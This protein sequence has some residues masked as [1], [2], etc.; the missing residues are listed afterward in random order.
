MSTETYH[1]AFGT[2]RR[3][4]LVLGRILDMAAYCFKPDAP[5][6]PPRNLDLALGDGC[7]SELLQVLEDVQ[8]KILP[9]AIQV[10][11]PQAMAHM[12]P[13][14][15]TV[16]VVADLL[17]GLMN[18][19]AFIWEEAPVA[20]AL[21]AEV[22]RWLCDQLHLPG[23]STAYLTS[24]GTASNHLATLCAIERAGRE[25]A[26]TERYCIVASDQAHLSLEKAAFATGLGDH[27]V[28]R[29]PTDKRGR[30]L[31]GRFG[32]T[33]M[34]VRREGRRPI[35]FVCTA[36]TPSAGLIEPID[37]ILQTARAHSGWCHV[38]AAYGGM[39][40]MSRGSNESA[41]WADADSLSWD[42]HKCLYVTY[43]SGAF[44][45]RDTEALRCLDVHGDYALK[46]SASAD[47]GARHLDGSRRLEALKLWMTI[48]YFG[49]EGF[50]DMTER[51]RHA[52]WV[53]ARHVRSCS[54]FELL[55]EPDTNVVCFRY[56]GGGQ[57]ESA[58]DSVNEAVQHNLFR[59]GGP[60]VST[61][62]VGGRVWLRAVL[63]NP[64]VEECDIVTSL[65][66]IRRE[67]ERQAAGTDRRNAGGA[68][69]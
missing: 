1:D 32:E 2:P 66:S 20:S 51:T 10:R 41:R 18:Q 46:A 23:H 24:G 13:P 55:T 64:R 65:R 59:T 19:C 63:L 22:L 43:A 28:V 49:R 54:D 45:L 35:L 50:A 42:P 67:A 52:A 8:Q 16:A 44:F 36:G 33:A 17:I 30:L 58:S 38:D 3:A 61:T 48:K 34:R 5:F 6:A 21:E 12:V 68:S 47:P 9:H 37:E 39:L 40:C 56:V 25:A 14:P 15:A 29:V 57:A 26:R 7:G 27:S 4:A 69:R 11:H 53:F 62:R 31:P 60:L